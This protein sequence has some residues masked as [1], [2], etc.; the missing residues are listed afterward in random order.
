MISN[1]EKS[2]M[3]LNYCNFFFPF[4]IGLSLTPQPKKKVFLKIYAHIPSAIT[5]RK[6]V[7]MSETEN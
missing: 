5:I 2:Q 7:Y 6:I 4:L 1:C 3:V